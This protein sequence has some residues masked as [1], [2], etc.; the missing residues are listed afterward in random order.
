[1]FHSLDP[2]FLKVLSGSKLYFI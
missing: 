1:M 2:I